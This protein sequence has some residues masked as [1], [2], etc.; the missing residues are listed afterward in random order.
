MLETKI[1]GPC[2][3]GDRG[4]QCLKAALL[5]VLLLVDGPPGR[6]SFVM[7]DIQNGYCCPDK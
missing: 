7:V 6:D 2:L 5:E 1:R 3:V 4:A